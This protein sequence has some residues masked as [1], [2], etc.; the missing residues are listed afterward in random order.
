MPL[1]YLL[2][3]FGV[4]SIRTDVHVPRQR[5][6]ANT[7]NYG[8][9][10]D[11]LALLRPPRAAELGVGDA[12]FVHLRDR[13]EVKSLVSEAGIM[14]EDRD[15]DVVFA[16]AAEADG[17]AVPGAVVEEGRGGVS[18]RVGGRCSLDTFFRARHH[19]LAQTLEVSQPF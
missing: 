2:Q 19:L 12:H 15:F 17:E 11:A 3:V 8:N 13:E 5:S 6:V 16:M 18:G 1:S 7:H 10:P 4:P 14:L 9:E